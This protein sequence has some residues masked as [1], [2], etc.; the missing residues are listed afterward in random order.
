MF[1]NAVDSNNINPLFLKVLTPKLLSYYTLLFNT[2]LT[3]STFPKHWKLAKIL[4]IPKTNNDFRAI[5]ILPFLSKVMASVI[6][7]QT[8]NYLE[9]HNYLYC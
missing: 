2:G 5:A 4:P 8:N 1:P 9:S 6:A 7:R 3:K